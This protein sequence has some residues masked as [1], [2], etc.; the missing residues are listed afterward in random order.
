MR[1]VNTPYDDVF[2]TLINEVFGER[3]SGKE[4]IVFSPNEHFMNRQDGEE[5]E[6]VSDTSFKII[7]GTETKK[8]HWECQSSADSSMLVRFFEYD[9]QIALDEGEIKKDVLTMKV[10]DFHSMDG[11]AARPTAG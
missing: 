8:Y 3:Y 10:F 11:H 5:G 2:R 4:K 1:F 7:A 6:R 9:T